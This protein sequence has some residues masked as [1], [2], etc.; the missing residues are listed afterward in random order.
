MSAWQETEFGK[1]PSHW[2]YL[3]IENTDLQIGDGNYSSKYPRASELLAE[4]IPFISSTDLSNGKISADN[5]R[6]I[7][8]EHHSRLLKGHIKQGDVLI[9]VRGN[10]VGQVGLVSEEYEDANLN[11][12]MAYLGRSNKIDGAFLFYLLSKYYSDGVTETVVSGSAQPQITVSSL[13]QLSLIVPPV[14]EQKAIA[15]VLSSLDDKIDLLHR[16]NKTLEDMAEALFRQWFVEEA[17][18]DWAEVAVGDYVELNRT[19]IDKKY[20]HQTIEYLDTGSLTEGKIESI[21]PFT[22]DEAPSRAKRLVQH[23]DV[24]ISTVRPDQK[25]YGIIKNPVDNLVVSTG[26]CV[27]TCTKIDPHFIYLL[28]TNDEMTAYLHTLAEGSTSTYPSLKPSDIGAIVF[29]LPPDERLKEF[30]AIAHNFLEKIE[31]NHIQIRTLEKLRDTL[32]PKL[33]SGEVRVE[34]NG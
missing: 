19:S 24:L 31:K 14:D 11:A 23:N 1:I 4:G 30:S 8:T 3:R 17:Q 18:E 10:G 6:Y 33:M 29:Q 20:P 16:Q 25:H 12:Q 13:K 34:I 22:L 28:L 9:V 27:L 32:L 21:Q 2:D 5:L 7:S 26:F 15:A